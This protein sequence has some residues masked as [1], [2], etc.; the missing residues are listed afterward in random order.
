MGQTMGTIEGGSFRRTYIADEPIP[1]GVAV[2]AGAAYNSVKLTTGA[3]VRALGIS[4]QAAEAAGRPIPVMEFG[5][6]RCVADDAF[7][8]STWLMANAATGK[9]AAIGAVAGTN[10]EVVGLALEA[11]DGQDDEV[12]VFVNPARVQG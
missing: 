2:M 9:L 6:T 1:A 4:L 7:A 10:Y 5:E 12:V 8:R 3:N 11:S